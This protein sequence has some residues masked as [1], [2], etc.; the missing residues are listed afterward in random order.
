MFRMAAARSSGSQ[1]NCP[2]YRHL[3]CRIAGRP[4][5][6][7]HRCHYHGHHCIPGVDNRVSVAVGLYQ[8]GAAYRE[9]VLYPLDAVYPEGAL[10]SLDS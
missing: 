5:L 3:Y 2:H 1:L 4:Y 6:S 10:Y 7:C 9:D 8:S